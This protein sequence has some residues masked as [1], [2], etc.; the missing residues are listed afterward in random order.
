MQA[1]GWFTYI[2]AD[3]TSF[4]G[5]TPCLSPS[6]GS[7]KRLKASRISLSSWAVTLCSFA[8]LDWRCFGA[9]P[10]AFLFG[11]YQA[12]QYSSSPS[13]RPARRCAGVPFCCP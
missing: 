3:R 8:S 1:L 5:I 11:G 12:G 9:S 7:E 2:M 10:G 13:Q 4:V 6:I